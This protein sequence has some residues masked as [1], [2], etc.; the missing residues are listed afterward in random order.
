MSFSRCLAERMPRPIGSKALRR[1]GAAMAEYGIPLPPEYDSEYNVFLHHYD[2]VR[3]DITADISA[4]DLCSAAGGDRFAWLA[5]GRTKSRDT[6]LD[7]LRDGKQ[8]DSIRD[9][10][11]VRIVANCT[12]TQQDAIVE[13]LGNH[14][15]A[16]KAP[17]DR[18]ANPASGYRA[19]HL[20]VRYDGTPVEI[21]VRTRLQHIWAEIYEGLGDK[22]GR[23]IRYDKDP[24]D[25]DPNVAKERTELVRL[26]R[27]IS[28]QHIAGVEALIDRQANKYL[29]NREARRKEAK[30]GRKLI[31]LEVDLENMLHNW[32][33]GFEVRE[34]KHVPS[35]GEWGRQ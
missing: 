27:S 25:P 17:I 16:T 4:L 3:A 29:P 30:F 21:Q 20:E 35:E 26:L 18:R 5:V 10:A 6:L 9:V 14:F 22:W 8:L 13:Y 28:T 32:A 19:V 12:L 1:L 34:L 7:K 24:E 15:S 2:G 31:K 23:G 33:T 11:G